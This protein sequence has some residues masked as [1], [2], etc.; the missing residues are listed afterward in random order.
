VCRRLW[1]QLGTSSCPSLITPIGSLVNNGTREKTRF[2][3]IAISHLGQQM[4]SIGYVCHG[5]G[6][7]VSTIRFSSFFSETVHTLAE[8]QATLASKADVPLDLKN[9]CTTCEFKTRCRQIAIET[10]NLSLI[11]TLGDKERRRL[12][13]KGINTI[14]QLSYG[15][16]QHRERDHRHGGT[17][18]GMLRQII[19]VSKFWREYAGHLAVEA[20]DDKVMRE[21]PLCS[22]TSY[23][24]A[25]AGCHQHPAAQASISPGKTSVANK[26]AQ[27]YNCASSPRRAPAMRSKYWGAAKHCG[28]ART[29]RRGS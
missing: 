5:Y 19:R 13:Q 18:A 16:I 26:A 24:R 28:T 4:P 3:S 6:R 17:S 7:E 10:D 21:L 9:Y 29:H 2:S 25:A 23:C 15:Y 11:G 1:W 20:I 27:Q 22:R 12:R 14:A 8:A